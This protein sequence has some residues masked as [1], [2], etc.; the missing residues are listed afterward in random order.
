VSTV[1]LILSNSAVWMTFL[2]YCGIVILMGG[3]I[4]RQSMLV[5]FSILQ[6]V[7]AVPILIALG[8]LATAIYSVLGGVVGASKIMQAIAR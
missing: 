2:T 3:S 8:S 7:S 4:D 6:D 5:D 1:T